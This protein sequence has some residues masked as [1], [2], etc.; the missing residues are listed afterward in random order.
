MGRPFPQA[1]NPAYPAVLEACL[2]EANI[3]DNRLISST[4]KEEVLRRNSI[5]SMES[6]LEKQRRLIAPYGKSPNWALE[7]R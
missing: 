7:A 6:N 5:K 4:S 2:A 3:E 1:S